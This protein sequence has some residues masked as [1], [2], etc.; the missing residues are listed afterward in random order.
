MTPILAEHKSIVVSATTARDSNGQANV[1]TNGAT[2]AVLSPLQAALSYLRAGLSFLPVKTDGTKAPDARLLPTVIDA[3][4]ERLK[5]T[6][7]PLKERMPTEEEVGQWFG[8]PHPA[9]I[10][11]IGGRISGNAENIDIDCGDI[12]A[13]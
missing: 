1:P 3:S 9:G 10:G 4:Q 7:A 11:I 13:P 8:S 2:H 5:A 12:F 6:W